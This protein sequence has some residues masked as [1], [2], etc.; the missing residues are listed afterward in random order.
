[1]AQVISDSAPD[2][3]R[4]TSNLPPLTAAS[5]NAKAGHFFAS[6]S[7]LEGKCL[8]VHVE[9]LASAVSILPTFLPFGSP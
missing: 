3:G 1:M 9:M 7:R 5:A 6:C 4:L 2:I 8:P